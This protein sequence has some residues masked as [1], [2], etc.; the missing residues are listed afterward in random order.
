MKKM[1]INIILCVILF[2]SGLFGMLGCSMG[3]VHTNQSDLSNKMVYALPKG[4]IKV[5]SNG[6]TI[7]VETVYEPDENHYYLLKYTPNIGFADDITMDVNEKGFLSSIKVT[8]TSKIPDIIKKAAEIAVSALEIPTV[9][10]ARAGTPFEVIIDPANI[11]E[12]KPGKPGKKYNEYIDS[13]SLEHPKATS[14]LYET[15]SESASERPPDVNQCICYRPALPFK[16]RLT[17]GGTYIERVVSL[18]NYSKLVTFDITRPAFVQ[19]V[20]NLTFT[21]GLLTQVN[22][23]QD[24]E[25]LAALG[26]PAD[27][28][29]TVAGLPIELIKFQTQNVQGE[30]GLLQAQMTLIQAQIDLQNKKNQSQTDREFYNLKQDL[31]RIEEELRK[32]REANPGPSKK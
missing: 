27:L 13:I 5:A 15:A 25:L 9:K 17:V 10:A 19:K 1:P 24:S 11:D 7:T 18:P 21:N 20:Q 8:T 23:K 14:F 2:S 28:V 30:T 6:T 29:K 31:G 12:Y 16:L 32:L 3:L 4:Y 22:L 26:I